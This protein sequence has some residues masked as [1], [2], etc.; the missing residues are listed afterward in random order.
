MGILQKA[1]SREVLWR[2]LHK[3]TFLETYFVKYQR[4]YI[5]FRELEDSLIGVISIIHEQRD[6][7]S[8]LEKDLK[9]QD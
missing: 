9:L 4:H 8:L 3:Q 7:V 6:I 1:A 2:K 5:F